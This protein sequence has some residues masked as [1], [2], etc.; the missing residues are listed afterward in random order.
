MA[1][2]VQEP[3]ESKGLRELAVLLVVQETKAHQDP[4]DQLVM[5]EQLDVKDQLV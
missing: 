5:L 1:P 4:R 3:K 2:E